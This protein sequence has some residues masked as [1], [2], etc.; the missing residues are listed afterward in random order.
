[1]SN[2]NHHYYLA[3]EYYCNDFIASHS[4]VISF[5]DLAP[6]KNEEYSWKIFVIS[7]KVAIRQDLNLSLPALLSSLKPGWMPDPVD[8]CNSRSAYSTNFSS[9]P[10]RSNLWATRF[11]PP[12]MSLQTIF[13][14]GRAN[15]KWSSLPAQ[16]TVPRFWGFSIY[17]YCDRLCQ[18]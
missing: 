18:D 3:K 13:L 10:I 4:T 6:M 7:S 9:S 1:M 15:F 8:L 12:G 17:G 5:P 14:I 11:H 2:F 16:P